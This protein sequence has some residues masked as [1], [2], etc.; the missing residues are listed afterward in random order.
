MNIN[1]AEKALSFYSFIGRA[2]NG[3]DV[4][5][6]FASTRGNW[7]TKGPNQTQPVLKTKQTG[8]QNKVKC[9]TQTGK[10]NQNLDF[11]FEVDLKGEEFPQ[12]FHLWIKGSAYALNSVTA[13]SIFWSCIC[14][15]LFL[16]SEFMTD[17]MIL[18]LK[19]LLLSS[20]FWQF[21]HLSNFSTSFLI[22][23]GLFC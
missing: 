10:A 22:C 9:K 4:A 2:I 15:F 21:F 12:S 8:F 19:S 16:M 6:C 23:T 7:E 1:R 11:D 17:E 3:G 5:L 14:E 13:T 20:F 18:K